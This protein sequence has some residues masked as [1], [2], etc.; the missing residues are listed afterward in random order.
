MTTRR[1]LS[2]LFSFD[3]FMG[4]TVVLGCTW[5]M[6]QAY[7]D[8]VAP[9]DGQARAIDCRE[10]GKQ[11]LQLTPQ[12][13]RQLER[14]GFVV[15]DDFLSKQEVSNAV[16]SIQGESFQASPSEPDDDGVVR[17]DHHFFFQNKHNV[18]Q[19]GLRAVQNS[20]YRLGYDVVK[21]PFRGFNDDYSSKWL[22]AP[23]MM[24]VSRFEGCNHEDAGYFD[25]HRDAVHDPFLQMGIMGYFKSL[26]TRR[27]Y[28]TCIVYLNS[29]WR[30]GDG[31]C[32]RIIQKDGTPMDVEPRGGR[33]VV[34][35][36]VDMLHGVQPTFA[37]RYACSVWLTLNE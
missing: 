7:V 20:L 28:L 21:S 13:C 35:S 6:G 18:E 37:K 4:G 27:R 15:I 3:Q 12:V 10:N 25:A 14:D 36:S 24:Q 1:A 31:G 30:D 17:K 2:S 33:L 22:G 34:F 19:E 32:L 26:Y 29:N 16:T 8:G 9:L 11:R 5:W 23:K